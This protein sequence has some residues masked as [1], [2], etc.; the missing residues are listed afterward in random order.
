M[1]VD[2]IYQCW[3]DHF[4][5]ILDE[6]HEIKLEYF[7]GQN[8]VWYKCPCDEEDH[9]AARFYYPDGLSQTLSPVLT[10]FLSNKQWLVKDRPVADIIRDEELAYLKLL[11]R[12]ESIINKVVKQLGKNDETLCYLWQTYGIAEEITKDLWR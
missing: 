9:A 3:L 5:G 7:M 10:C 2:E 11:E 1:K 4:E 12:S 8:V 6:V